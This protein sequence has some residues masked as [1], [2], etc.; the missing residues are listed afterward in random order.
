MK[1]RMKFVVHPLNGTQSKNK[2]NCVH[3]GV[4][5]GTDKKKF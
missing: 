3:E 5:D 1:E 2:I 4:Q